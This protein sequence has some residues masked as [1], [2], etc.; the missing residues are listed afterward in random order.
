VHIDRIKRT[1]VSRLNECG[2]SPSVSVIST[3]FVAIDFPISSSDSEDESELEESTTTE[4]VQRSPPLIGSTLVWP[5]SEIQEALSASS[6]ASL[7]IEILI[8]IFQLLPINDLANVSL[9][10]RYFKM[11]AGQDDVWRSRC[12][13]KYQVDDFCFSSCVSR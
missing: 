5:V 11:I 1:L 9:V 2:Y 8:Q 3:G 10:C 4:A 13:R 6:F 12:N 7:P